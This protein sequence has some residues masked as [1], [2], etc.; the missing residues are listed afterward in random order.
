[1]KK[2][3]KEH[4]TV[5]HIHTHTQKKRGSVNIEQDDPRL[6]ELIDE[7][8]LL[9]AEEYFSKEIK[10]KAIIVTGHFHGWVNPDVM[11]RHGIESSATEA[12]EKNGGGTYSYL[13]PTGSG[14][15]RKKGSI[16]NAKVKLFFF[17]FLYVCIIDV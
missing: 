10:D 2:R 8:R 11:K 13:D 3:D 15:K 9:T 4:Y 16:S 5:G 12:W 17:F 7:G 14:N 6:Q 1:M